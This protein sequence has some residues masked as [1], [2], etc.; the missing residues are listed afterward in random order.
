MVDLTKIRASIE[1][2]PARP[3]WTVRAT[4]VWQTR[5]MP[6]AVDA[7]AGVREDRRE[8]RLVRQLLRAQEKLSQ[9]WGPAREFNGA[10]V[11]GPHTPRWR[12]E[13]RKV[14][15]AGAAGKGGD[16]GDCKACVAF[17]TIASTEARLALQ[18]PEQHAGLDLSEAHLFNCGQQG[19]CDYGW[20]VTLALDWAMTNGLLLESQFPQ[21]LGG[22]CPAPPP[23][24]GYWIEDYEP[25]NP[26]LPAAKATIDSDGPAIAVMRVYED[27]LAYGDDS[28]PYWH[29]AG[30]AIGL[31]AVTILGH[32]AQSWI[33]LNSW[34]SDWGSK[35]CF[36]ILHGECEIDDYFFFAPL[37]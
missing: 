13:V 36:R 32:D 12:D 24:A 37:V 8:R 19:G 23:P 31:H 30:K 33:G 4:D 17:A 26:T 18:Y 1:G 21:L 20:E 25:L 14:W 10:R 27:F 9:H 5:R 29:A 6:P 28:E 7:L 15:L 11:L 34:G 2:K 35:G 3:Q 22:A 16:Q